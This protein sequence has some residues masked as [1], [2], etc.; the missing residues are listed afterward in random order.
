MAS[1]AAAAASPPA[2][3]EEQLHAVELCLKSHVF[4]LLG[5]PGTGKTTVVA[6]IYRRKK[7]EGRRVLILGPT[8][9][10]ASRARALVVGGAPACTADKLTQ[11]SSAP[12]A[13]ARW[14]HAVVIMDEASM[15][16][17]RMICSVLR[18]LQ[19]R[20]ETEPCVSQ[21]I[22]VGDD[23]Q[24]PPTSGVSCLAELARAYPCARL[25]TVYRQNKGTALYENIRR[26]KTHA[27]LSLNSFLE[28]E[29]FEVVDVDKW[30]GYAF[31]NGRI[32]LL[33]AGG[34][35]LP[36][37][38]CLTNKQRAQMTVQV[39]NAA[40]PGGA[41]AVPA[42]KIPGKEKALTGIRLGDPVVCTR[43]KYAKGNSQEARAFL[44]ASSHEE[45]EE[46]SEDEATATSGED[47]LLVSN[48]TP[49]VF[50]KLPSG[51][52]GV[53]Y[54]TVSPRGE[55]VDFWDVEDTQRSSWNPFLTKFEHGY[56]L[57]V[58]KAQGDQYP[59]VLAFVEPEHAFSARALLYTAV[60]RAKTKCVLFTSDESL[61]KMPLRKGGKTAL[62]W[63]LERVRK[64]T[65]PFL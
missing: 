2:L 46:E 20:G 59:E 49:G 9:K 60:S 7:L 32:L 14:R 22:F 24:L 1:A 19:K 55:D 53:R 45:S 50:E 11:S 18:T 3:D 48:G 10:A 44:H 34:K 5:E 51:A 38:L 54:R 6:E 56:A 8:A 62:Q 39:Q 30:S 41:E 15:A 25:T 37:V 58:Y 27:S 64:E 31:L 36:A 42:R 17:P 21:I 26:I 61:A 23:H 35:P 65:T 4:V 63:E 16:Y 33:G 12:T 52:K 43:N 28:D 57:T 13:H 40:N 47:L 29:S